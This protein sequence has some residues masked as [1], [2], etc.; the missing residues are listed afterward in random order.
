MVDIGAEH[1][2]VTKPVAP[3]TEHRAT[4]IGATDT[5]TDQQFC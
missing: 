5:Q 2:M 3:L 1:P 4:I